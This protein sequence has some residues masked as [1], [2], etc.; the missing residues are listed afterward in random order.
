MIIKRD[1]SKRFSGFPKSLINL[2]G[3]NI[4][5]FFSNKNRSAVRG[6]VVEDH[7]LSRREKVVNLSLNDRRN[8]F[9]DQI[10]MRFGTRI[11][12]VTNK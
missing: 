4:F 7:R 1:L 10:S 9:T 5:F 11:K 12:L 3:L 6:E 8:R 2:V